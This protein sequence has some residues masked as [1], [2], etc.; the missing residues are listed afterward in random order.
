MVKERVEWYN[1][2]SDIKKSDILKSMIVMVLYSSESLRLLSKWSK[3]LYDL[4][5]YDLVL[6]D[7]VLYD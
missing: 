5:L 2:K 6:Y 1:E 4:V 3:R 7:L